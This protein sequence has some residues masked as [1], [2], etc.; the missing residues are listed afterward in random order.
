MKL[1]MARVDDR[2]IHGQVVVAC[3]EATGARRLILANDEAASDAMQQRLYRAAVPPPAELEIH[4]LDGAAR[5][6]RE[7]DEAGDEVPTLLVVESPQDMLHLVEEDA[8]ISSV[9]LGGLHHHPGSRER[10][11]GFYLDDEQEEAVRQLSE[12]GIEV[13]AQTIPGAPSTD[14]AGWWASQ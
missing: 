3:R 6:L 5:R 13:I 10:W 1:A 2:L 9:T 12:R 11:P 4:G 8:P 7:L 14:A